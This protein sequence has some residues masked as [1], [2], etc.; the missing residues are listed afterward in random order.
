[1]EQRVEQLFKRLNFLGY[2]GFAMKSIIQEAIGN[3]KGAIFIPSS[4]TITI[5]EKYEKLG[6]DYL[7]EYSK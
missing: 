7:L 5:L 2:C 3:A 4:E 6:S 1:M